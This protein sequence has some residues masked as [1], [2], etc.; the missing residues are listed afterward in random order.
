MADASQQQGRCVPPQLASVGARS[1]LH[2]QSV[3]KQVGPQ[4]AGHQLV[5]SRSVTQPLQ[6]VRHKGNCAREGGTQSYAGASRI[7]RLDAENSSSL[8]N[9]HSR[10][11]G[12]CS[13]HI[14][15]SSSVLVVTLL[16]ANA[17]MANACM[18]KVQIMSSI[19][20]CTCHG[21]L[22]A[23]GSQR[24]AV[25]VGARATADV[26]TGATSAGEGAECRGR[27]ASRAAEPGRPATFAAPTR[28]TQPAALLQHCR[29]CP[30]QWS[31]F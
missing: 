28:A 12:V 29:G 27:A 19:G 5:G 21:L 15:T 25:H 17:T 2:M 26:E 1:A 16:V 9:S 8:F 11:A 18:Q 13:L 6:S 24:V 7:G 23:Q 30:T 22:L 3:V 31:C 4:R 20:L 14:N 10:H